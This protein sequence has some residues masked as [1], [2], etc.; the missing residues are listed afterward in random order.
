MEKHSRGVCSPKHKNI[1][2]DD[3]L[4]YLERGDEETR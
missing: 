3:A 4:E 1:D 2:N